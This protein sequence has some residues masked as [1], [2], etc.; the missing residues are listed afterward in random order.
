MIVTLS[1]QNWDNKDFS[2][3]VGDIKKFLRKSKMKHKEF[4]LE[5]VR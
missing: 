2:N 4:V 1:T 5:K 3:V